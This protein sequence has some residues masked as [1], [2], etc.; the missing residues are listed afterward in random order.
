MSAFQSILKRLH[1]VF[2]KE[3]EAVP[4]VILTCTTPFSLSV[5]GL[6]LKA[7]SDAGNFAVDLSEITLAQLVATVD[8]LGGYTASLA[9]AALGALLARGL[10]DV[11]GEY[12]SAPEDATLGYPQSLLFAE[13]RTVGWMLDEQAGRIKDAERQMYPHM[14]EGEWADYWCREMFG[15]PRDA[16]EEDAGYV[17]RTI[18][19]LIRPNQNN[20]A[21]ELIILE[22]LGVETTILDAW[23]NR[24]ELE[25]S[26]QAKAAGHFLLD[27]AI[28]NDLSTEAAQ[29]LIDRVKD[30]VRKHK[31]AGTDFLE[32]VLSKLVNRM[33]ALAAD[34]AFTATVVVT[35]AETLLGGP[36]Q[37]GAGWRVGAPGLVVGDNEALKEQIFVQKIINEGG[38][39]ESFALYGG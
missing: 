25:P 1:R 32:T 34:E 30:L 37:V 31:A 20:K 12:A 27:M 17:V 18:H 24:A 21:L 10:L 29:A 4:A 11:V 6:T 14:S 35:L 5:Q 36:V 8:A 9:D 28:D 7:E 39:V 13:L 26:A 22:A 19:E 2:N 15:I 23:P 3:P 16:G 38:A 33:E